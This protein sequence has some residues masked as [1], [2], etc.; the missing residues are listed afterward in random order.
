MNAFRHGTSRVI[1]A[2]V[3]SIGLLLLAPARAGL[4]ISQVYGGGGNTGATYTND[5]IE[6]FNDDGIAVSLNGLSVQYA[7]ATGTGLFGSATNLRTELPNVLLQP[8]HY[9][10]IQEAIGAG[11]TTPLPTPDLID[12]TPINMSATAGKVALVSGTSSLGCN[13][14]STPCS[15]AQLALILDL[16]GYGN[17]NFFEGTGAAPTLG[18]TTAAL[19]INEPFGSLQDTNDNSVDFIELAPNPRNTASP[20]NVPE[21]ATLALLALGLAGLGFSRRRQ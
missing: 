17:A 8:W 10:L 12:G 4:V 18:N 3:A 1:L 13:G 9:F 2:V 16:V 6:L 21:P 5:F 11:G 7:S 14:G 19:R 20:R 15:T